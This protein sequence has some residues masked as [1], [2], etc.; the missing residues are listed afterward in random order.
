[1]TLGPAII[2]VARASDLEAAAKRESD[3]TQNRPVVQG[4]AAHTRK[5]WEIMRDHFRDDLEDRLIACIRAR[6][7]EYE[8]SKLAR[9]GWTY[10]SI[11]RT[12][13]GA[14]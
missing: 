3:D 6:N 5:R 1:M 11:G 8:P 13:H 10:R 12:A 4:L 14:Q 7:M 9:M 2:P